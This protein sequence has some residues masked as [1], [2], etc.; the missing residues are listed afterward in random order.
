ME[1]AIEGCRNIKWA[2]ALTLDRLTVIVMIE[3]NQSRQMYCMD[4]NNSCR[5]FEN[6]F[7]VIITHINCF[8]ISKWA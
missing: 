7:V 3:C 2:N 5:Y 4:L 6:D 1:Y 8:K